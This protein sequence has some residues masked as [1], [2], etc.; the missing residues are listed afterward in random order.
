MRGDRLADVSRR[1]TVS[2]FPL[3][4]HADVSAEPLDVAWFSRLEDF[5]PWQVNAVAVV[6][7]VHHLQALELVANLRRD[8]PQHLP[9]VGNRRLTAGRGRR[10]RV[11]PDL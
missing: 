3:E 11:K 1:Q 8:A 6:P 7:H 5:L 9:A 2:A 4:F 10:H